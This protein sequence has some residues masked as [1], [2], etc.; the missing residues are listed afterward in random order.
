MS[1]AT[2]R[3]YRPGAWFGVFGDH[4][5]VLLPP[6]G[7]SRVA[8]L[9][10]LVD[11]GAGFDEVLDELI[12][13]GLRELPTFV[14]ISELGTDT[15]VVIRGAG[16]A[17]FVLG[18]ETVELEGSSATTWVER[19]FTSV[20]SM[21]IDVE[22]GGDVDGGDLTVRTGLVR[23]SRVDAPPR[24]TSDDQAESPGPSRP[25]RSPTSAPPPRPWP[26]RCRTHRR[27]VGTTTG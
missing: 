1:E 11:D 22:D 6:T 19:T 25:R 14:L 17:C 27:P 4:A 7:K 21:S 26:R 10:E 24:T 3:S 20:T 18:D 15:K 16:R 12:S 2:T 13:G 5:T 9:W 23:V 8:R